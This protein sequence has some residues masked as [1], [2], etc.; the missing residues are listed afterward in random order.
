MNKTHAAI[1]T[2]HYIEINY[3]KLIKCN[4]LKVINNLCSSQMNCNKIDFSFS[5]CI[6]L[7]SIL[8]SVFLYHE[9]M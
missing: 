1:N 7:L 5:A 4:E 6:I 3:I 8:I 2:I 9:E